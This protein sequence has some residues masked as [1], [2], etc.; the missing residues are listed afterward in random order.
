LFK[1]EQFGQKENILK[2]YDKLTHS[3]LC[4]HCF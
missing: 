4:T 3:L 1:L 2:T